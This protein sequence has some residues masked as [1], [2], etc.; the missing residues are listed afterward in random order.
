M[1]QV[2][3]IREWLDALPAG[4][5]VGVDEGG[6]ILTTRDGRAWLEIGGLPVEDEEDDHADD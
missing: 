4:T 3:E 5:W 1:M 6:L 2:E